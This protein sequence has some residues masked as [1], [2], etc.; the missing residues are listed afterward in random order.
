M[1]S[2]C[3]AS[4]PRPT[5]RLVTTN[6]STN[7]ATFM[8]DSPQPNRA[9]LMR[10]SSALQPLTQPQPHAPASHRRLPH[11]PPREEK[12]GEKRD[13]GDAALSCG[14]R[15]NIQHSMPNRAAHAARI[16]R[17]VFEVECSM[18]SFHAGGGLDSGLPPSR[19]L[20]S[21]PSTLS[22]DRPRARELPGTPPPTAR[23]SGDRRSSTARWR[24]ATARGFPWCKVTST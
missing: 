9:L 5:R 10:T 18:F 16:E 3:S 8:K 17:S 23:L 1:R 13:L 2:F 21:Q 24:R 22:S 11:L 14:Q 4:G 12:A 19:P 7:A 15:R 6:D 20:H